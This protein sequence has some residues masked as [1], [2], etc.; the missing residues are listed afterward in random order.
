MKKAVSVLFASAF[1][2][3]SALANES[4]GGIG[5]TIFATSDGVRVV[6]VIPGSPAADAGLESDDRIVAVDGGSIAGN[7]IDAS[8]DLLRGT[9]GKP[10]ELSVLREKD[11]LSVTLRRAQIAVTD[12]A[13]SA[14]E[15]WYGDSATSYSAAEIAEVA[16]KSLAA[17]Y[18]LLSV[19][20]DG[21]VVS[22]TAEVFS[23]E[24]SSVSVEKAD[25]DQDAP[26]V[27]SRKVRAA[28]TLNSFDR[29]QVGF[30]LRA[31]GTAVVRVV[32]ANGEV[33]ARVVKEG[34]L[35]GS[36]SVT[37]SGRSASSGRYVVH[38]EQNGAKSA[39]PVE[40]R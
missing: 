21:R 8:K 13:A 33:V 22:D 32:S 25:S 17:N 29:E 38:I 37:W 24:L 36:Q 31:E 28:G 16:K 7:T 39:F 34:A 19:M 12:L 4:F 15:E 6:D 1:L 18:E 14:V 2:A 3:A 23:S 27:N 5:V 9:V 10:V 35:A 40:L 30:T 26:A 11:T 20:Q